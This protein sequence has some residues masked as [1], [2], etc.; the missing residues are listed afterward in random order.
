[1]PLPS[2]DEVLVMKRRAAYGQP[3]PYEKAPEA[4]AV[5]AGTARTAPPLTPLPRYTGTRPTPAC[6]RCR[7]TARRCGAPSR[8][9]PTAPCFRLLQD[10]ADRS[11]AA[12]KRLRAAMKAG[13][14]ASVKPAK[15]RDALAE[16]ST[17]GDP[18]ALRAVIAEA[19]VKL[20]RAESKGGARTNVAGAAAV[21]PGAAAV[22]RERRGVVAALT[23]ILFWVNYTT[24]ASPLPSRSSSS[25]FCA[26]R[27]RL[28]AALQRSSMSAHASSSWRLSC[29]R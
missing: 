5:A 22:E 12:E 26:C 17:A 24:N 20:Q 14:F 13:L 4:C 16:A 19:G 15:L 25:V 21:E 1:M 3:C 18:H 9:R 27:I 29:E 6:L 8:R 2:E 23:A 7:P 11:A 28:C 10:A